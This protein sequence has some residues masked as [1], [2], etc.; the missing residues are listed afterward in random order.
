MNRNTDDQG[1]R[2]EA[3][4]SSTDR[5]TAH[6]QPDRTDRSGRRI[7]G[8]I[9]TFDFRANEMIRTIYRDGVVWFVAADVCGVLDL[10]NTS[11]TLSR[12]DD[13]E[14]NY[15]S[16]EAAGLKRRMAIVNESGLFALILTSRK[17]EANAFR[18]WITREVI[19]SVR[20][21]GEYRSPEADQQK[22]IENDV[23]I[24][25]KDH[26]V[27]LVI[28]SHER[29][30]VRKV[31]CEEVFAAF[32]YRL[33]EIL[34]HSVL[35]MVGSVEIA[36]MRNSVHLDQGIAAEWLDQNL[37]QAADVARRFLWCAQE[38][39]HRQAEKPILPS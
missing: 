11:Q 9:V 33:A 10:E 38:Q 17:P 23:R 24:K 12:L 5:Q 3:S 34:A 35:T 36:K 21:T 1:T 18:R 15:A 16:T 19:P 8:S 7:H 28:V 20:K 4:R 39:R 14:R 26:G 29:H 25:A 31:D 2:R 37:K 13:D 32:D 27:Y 6:P 22:T 30:T